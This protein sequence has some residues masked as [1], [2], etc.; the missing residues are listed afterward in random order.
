V[1]LDSESAWEDRGWIGGI[2]RKYGC[3]VVKENSYRI[4]LLD[5]ILEIWSEPCF[6]VAYQI[7]R[8]LVSK[9]PTLGALNLVQIICSRKVWAFVASHRTVLARIGIDS[10]AQLFTEFLDDQG[11]PIVGRVAAF[12][13]VIFLIGGSGIIPTQQVA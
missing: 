9:H 11:G 4:A 3:C 8:W 1:N 6:D 13:D 7:E 12:P 5:A 2:P 10:S